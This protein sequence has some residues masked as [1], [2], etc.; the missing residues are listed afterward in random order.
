MIKYKTITDSNQTEFNALKLSCQNPFLVALVLDKLK[1]KLC[2][3]EMISSVVGRVHTQMNS[4]GP[5]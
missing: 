3:V 5:S 4:A 2:S 1:A